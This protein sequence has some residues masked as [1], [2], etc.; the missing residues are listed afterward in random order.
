MSKTNKQ[1]EVKISR[2]VSKSPEVPNKRILR[3]QQKFTRDP[4]QP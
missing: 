1:I 4:K 3:N 2:V